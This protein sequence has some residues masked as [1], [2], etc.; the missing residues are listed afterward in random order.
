MSQ[1]QPMQKWFQISFLWLSCFLCPCYF[2]KAIHIR[3]FCVNLCQCDILNMK[4][5]AVCH[6]AFVTYERFLENTNYRVILLKR[7][8]RVKIKWTLKKNDIYD[9]KSSSTL[10]HLVTWSDP[11]FPLVNFQSICF[12]V[13]QDLGLMLTVVKRITSIYH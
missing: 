9:N 6:I 4:S 3:S 7:I 11:C 2:L 12:F 10:L 5:Q 13:T 1:C 8:K